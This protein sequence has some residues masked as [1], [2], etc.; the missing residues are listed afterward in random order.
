MVAKAPNFHD[1]FDDIARQILARIAPK[2]SIDPSDADDLRQQ[3]AI[4]LRRKRHHLESHPNPAAF[5]AKVARCRILDFLKKTTCRLHR[6]V[7]LTEW[8]SPENDQGDESGSA[9]FRRVP[10]PLTSPGPEAWLL[11]QEER[12]QMR[13][14]LR[15]IGAA[16]CGF[17]KRR[18]YI[19]VHCLVRERHQRDIA[20]ELGMSYGAVR[21]AVRDIRT[22]LRKATQAHNP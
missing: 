19:F 10:E 2:Y 11:E 5:I 13:Q 7:S 8:D 18:R 21:N 4:E 22:E 6:D 14:Q 1:D 16:V 3:I 15:A 20:N 9:G 17:S 12:K